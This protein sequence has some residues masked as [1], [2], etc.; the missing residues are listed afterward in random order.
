MKTLLTTS[1]IPVRLGENHNYLLLS[2][3]SYKKKSP[4]SGCLHHHLPLPLAKYA[5]EIFLVMSGNDF[6]EPW[7]PAELV[8]PL[9][10][11]VSC[12][13]AETREEG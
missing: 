4:A 2:L 8:Y 11:F 1:P 5:R 3:A 7:L 9:G 12:R 6:I 13:I 10:N